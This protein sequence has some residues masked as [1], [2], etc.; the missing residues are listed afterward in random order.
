[1]ARGFPSTLI[2]D[3][4]ELQFRYWH[5]VEWMIRWRDSSVE[6][7]GDKDASVAYTGCR[8]LGAEGTY[9]QWGPFEGL[10]PLEAPSGKREG[11]V[12]SEVVESWVARGVEGMG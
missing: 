9:I 8:E 10:V 4:T 2:H 11:D 7:L 3:L 12:D 1:M 5:F 6:P